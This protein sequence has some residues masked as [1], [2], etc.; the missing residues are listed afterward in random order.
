MI[1]GV[2]E[3]RNVLNGHRYVGSSSDVRWRFL[4]HQDDLQKGLHHSR[5]LQ[6]AWNKYSAENFVFR[7]LLR[8]DPDMLI[9]FE[10]R[11]MNVIKPEY[12]ISP[13][14][15]SPLGC[16]HSEE[17]KLRLS[18]INRGI[19]RTEDQ[20][21]A[22]S[23]ARQGCRH[24]EETISKMK[25]SHRRE[26]LSKETLQKMSLASRGR[27]WSKE[28]RTKHQGIRPSDET[29]QK[30]RIAKLG[31]KQSRE[32]IQKRCNTR[33]YNHRRLALLASLG[34]WV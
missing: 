9:F 32:T 23:L 25:I 28:T 15:G 17:T 3:I 1:A 6:R 14:A 20:N 29:R 4:C 16:K 13:T 26:N 22:R 10:Q 24:S 19:K 11:L 2:Y 21:R 33:A 8:C 5:Y 7:V 34:G 31:R 27:K 12:N 30:M 18:I